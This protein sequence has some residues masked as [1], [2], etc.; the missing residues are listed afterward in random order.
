[1]TQ[2]QGSTEYEKGYGESSGGC[3]RFAMDRLP[4]VLFAVITLAGLPLF[5]TGCLMLGDLAAYTEHSVNDMEKLNGG[6]K[7]AVRIGDVFES[8]ED[9]GPE[10][11]VAGYRFGKSGAAVLAQALL[12]NTTLTELRYCPLAGLLAWTCGC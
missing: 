10:K 9:A 7:D 12:V 5:H 1:M 6:L 4:I 11:R 3:S 8:G 2:S